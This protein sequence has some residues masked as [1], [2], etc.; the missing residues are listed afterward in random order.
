MLNFKPKYLAWVIFS[1][2]GM[3]YVSVM[4]NIEIHYFLKSLIIFLPIQLVT[5]I[6]ATAKLWGMRN[7]EGGGDQ[8]PH[9]H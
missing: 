1:L 9:V 4:S 7:S 3:G 5:V 6:Y 2:L 8:I